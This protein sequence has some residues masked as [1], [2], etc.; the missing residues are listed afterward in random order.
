MH[1][2]K[3]SDIVVLFDDSAYSVVVG[4][5]EG[6]RAIGERWNGDEGSPGFPSQGGNPLWHVVPEFLVRPILHGLLDELARRPRDSAAEQRSRI[7]QE[8]ANS[9]L[10]ESRR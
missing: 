8:L 6:T 4:R 5:Y 2:G 9:F 3:W 7:L 10:E 1:P